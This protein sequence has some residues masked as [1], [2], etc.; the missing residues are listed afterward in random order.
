MPAAG[1]GRH[2]L[3]ELGREIAVD[4]EADADLKDS[5]GGPSH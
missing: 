4:L 2:S 3:S 1:R 5:G